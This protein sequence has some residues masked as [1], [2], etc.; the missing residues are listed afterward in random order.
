MNYSCLP[1]KKELYIKK[2]HY[3]IM[4]LFYVDLNL[5]H[6]SKIKSGNNTNKKKPIKEVLY[7]L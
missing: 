4:K 7:H 2:K 6:L 5:E 3:L 1:K